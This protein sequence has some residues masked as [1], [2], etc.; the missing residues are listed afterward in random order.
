MIDNYFVT[1]ADKVG[2]EICADDKTLGLKGRFRFGNKYDPGLW[3]IALLG[4]VC[5]AI[6]FMTFGK[7]TTEIVLITVGIILIVASILSAIKYATD[8]LL[9]SNGVV[10]FR[11]NF[12][13]TSVPITK[14]LKL[15]MKMHKITTRNHNGVSNTTITIQHYLQDLTDEKVVFQF[16]MPK[17]D[18]EEAVKLGR[19]ISRRANGIFRR[20]NE[21]ICDH[22]IS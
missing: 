2:L 5:I 22:I 20:Y 13:Q 6:P 10:I 14:N 21:V 3:A 12:R 4:V 7:Q 8:R 18:S 1:I 19:E 17:E 15:K 9:I 11:F 16:S